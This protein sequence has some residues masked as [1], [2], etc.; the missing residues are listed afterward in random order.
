MLINFRR[1]KHFLF[2]FY[3]IRYFLSLGLGQ[4]SQS[5]PRVV[6]FKLSLGPTTT[7]MGGTVKTGTEKAALPFFTALHCF[8]LI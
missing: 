5:F 8:Q 3:K 6:K 1:K 4:N 2:L 7:T